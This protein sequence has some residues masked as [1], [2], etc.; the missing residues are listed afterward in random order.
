MESLEEKNSRNFE[1]ISVKDVFLKVNEYLGYFWTKKFYILLASLVFVGFFIYRAKTTPFKFTAETKFFMEG[2]AGG[3]GSGLGGLLG[4]IGMGGKKTNPFQIIE[5]A[6]SKIHITDVLFEKMGP[7]SVFIANKILEFYKLPEEWA[8]ENSKF[9]GF[10]FTHDSIKAFTYLENLALLKTIRKT[11]D[12]SKGDA[13]LTTGMEEEKGYYFIRSETIGHDLSFQL[14]E[15]S[16]E[17]LKYYF[18]EKTREQLKNTRDLLKIKNDSIKS[19]LNIKINALANFKD[20]N[21]SIVNYSDGVREIIL[22]SEINGLSGAYMESLKAYEMADYKYLDQKNYFML[23]D[24][25]MAPL[26]LVFLN[27]KIE[28]IKGAIL[29]ILLSFGFLFMVK[30]YQDIMN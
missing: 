28:A 5:V 9:D 25:P 24:K 22:E 16:Y 21:K 13:L 23:I 14:S 29:A 6:E 27:W 19:I 18:E 30:S 26:G 20:R 7:D 11:I 4:Q 15:V 2:D 8:K 12:N 3:G 1:E 10:K 17:K